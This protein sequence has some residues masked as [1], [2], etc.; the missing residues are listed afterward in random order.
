MSAMTD[1]QRYQSTAYM[2]AEFIPTSLRNKLLVWLDD[3]F[4][5]DRKFL[6]I[7]LSMQDM[8]LISEPGIQ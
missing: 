4:L 2:M 8:R 7:L 3:K 1:S 6:G 5:H